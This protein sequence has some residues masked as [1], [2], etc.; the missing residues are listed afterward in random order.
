M[1]LLVRL[2]AAAALG[3]PACAA[4]EVRDS[5]TTEAVRAQFADAF[6]PGDALEQLGYS[7]AS[8]A[9]LSLVRDGV[10]VRS[11]CVSDYGDGWACRNRLPLQLAADL[12][13]R[14]PALG[15][16]GLRRGEACQRHPVR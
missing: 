8:T 10:S 15:Q 6:E 9:T 1:R 3:L 14:D 11:F 4:D 12:G 16:D 7:E 5:D 13:G 2:T